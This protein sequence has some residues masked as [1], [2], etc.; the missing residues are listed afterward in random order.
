MGLVGSGLET[1]VRVCYSS[2]G[3]GRREGKREREKIGVPCSSREGG[4]GKVR[5]RIGTGMCYGSEECQRERVKEW[6]Y[7]TDQGAGGG[8]REMRPLGGHQNSL[9][10]SPDKIIAHPC[11][12][13]TKHYWP[14]FV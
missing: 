4:K 8:G 2:G 14:P 1:G 5:E 10:T 3:R 13:E 11:Y 7:V 9:S 6:G 12:K